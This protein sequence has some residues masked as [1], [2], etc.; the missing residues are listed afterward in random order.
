MVQILPG[1]KSRDS[2]SRLVGF[3]L[4]KRIHLSPDLSPFSIL[5]GSCRFHHTFELL[6]VYLAAFQH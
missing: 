2:C 3:F 6:L 5:P 4:Q 1:V